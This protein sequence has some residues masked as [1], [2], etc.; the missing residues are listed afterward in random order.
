MLTFD[1]NGKYSI[2]IELIFKPPKY[3][4]EQIDLLYK[5]TKQAEFNWLNNL[6]NENEENWFAEGIAQYYLVCYFNGI[7]EAKN[8]LINSREYLDG[9]AAEWQNE[10]MEILEKMGDI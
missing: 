7:D 9:S 2:E 5:R 4:K 6:P 8:E 1:D 10:C 3:E